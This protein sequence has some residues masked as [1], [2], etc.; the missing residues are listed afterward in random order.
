MSSRVSS[1]QLSILMPAYKASRTIGVA[2]LSSLLVMPRNSELLVHLD[3]PGTTSRVLEWASRHR[4]VRVLS[5]KSAIGISGALNNLILE[6]RGELVARM[7]ADDIS[8][9]FR[10]GRAV[11]LVRSGKADLVFLNA[12]LFGF[13]RC[14][15]F[16]I[17]QIPYPMS[18]SVSKLML[19]LANPFVHPTLVARKAAII[20]AGGYRPCVAEDY[21]LWMRAV[22]AG[23]KLR[24]ITQYG[25]LYR[26]H[27]DQYTQQANFEQKQASD[28]VLEATRIAYRSYLSNELATS[29]SGISVDE[30]LDRQ[31]KSMSFGYRVRNGILKRLISVSMKRLSA[32]KVASPNRNKQKDRAGRDN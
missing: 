19:G 17:P 7:D 6:S 3:G 13:G 16:I 14:L 30:T 8:L 18:H 12:M 27:K 23:L 2:I 11:R 10:F 25:V 24:R 31:L 28:P 15:P 26:V 22:M 20:K 21:E 4:R 1:T 5:S 32:S 29:S 9:P